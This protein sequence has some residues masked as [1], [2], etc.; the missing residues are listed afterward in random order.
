MGGHAFATSDPLLSTPRM[1]L[2]IYSQVLSQSHAVLRKYYNHVD[3][4]IE[5]PGKETYG[6]VDVLVFEPLDPTWENLEKGSAVMAE[7]IAEGLGAKKFLSQ[8]GN[9]TINFAVPWPGQRNDDEGKETKCVQVDVHVCFTLESFKWELFHAAHGDLWNILGSTIRQFGLT[10][11]DKGMYLRIP[12]IELYDRKKSMVFL[13]DNPSQ[14]IKFLGLNEERWWKPFQSKEEMFEYATGCRMF[15]VKEHTDATDGETDASRDN[16]VTIPG[17]EKQELEG[18]EGGERGRKKLKHNDRQR[19]AKRLIFREWID[20]FIPRC[21]ETGIFRDAKTSREQVRE[22]AFSEF[23]VK[24]EYDERL[25]N[26]MLVKH[27][28]DI[29]RVAIKQSVPIDGVDPPFRAAAIRTFKATILEGE[30]FESETPRP[31]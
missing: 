8:K 9:P 11:N 3:S 25:K 1:P 5:A 7:A 31:L 10:A 26:Y 15:W 30:K 23:G 29:W 12:E 2:N 6:D 16:I 19:M 22:D 18:L 27:Q 21:R 20:E 4:A 13:T 17:T 14:V 24:E 28:D